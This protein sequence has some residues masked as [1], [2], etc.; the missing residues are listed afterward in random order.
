MRK[1]LLFVSVAAIAAFANPARAQFCPGVSPW[2]FDDVPA[3]DPF[4]G[5]ITQIANQGV[6]LGCAVIDANHRLY[7]PDDNVKRSQMA[8]FMARLG[9]ALPGGSVKSLSQ[10]AGILLSSN[11]ITTTGSIAADTTYLQRRVTGS[12]ATGASIRVIAADGT[13]TCQPDSAGPANAF[14][15]NG[16][17]FGTTAAIGT[18]DAN[19]VHVIA[20]GARAL[21]LEPNAVSPNVIGGSSANN[22]TAGV[23]GGTIGG[24]GV[25]AGTTDPFFVNEGPN[26]VTDAYGTVAGGYNNRAGDDAGTQIDTPFATVGG[27]NQNVAGETYATVGGGSSNVATGIASTISGGDINVASGGRATVGGGAAHFASADYATIA[28]GNANDATGDYSTVGGGNLNA[29]NGNYSAVPG[30]FL[31]IASGVGSLAAGSRAE[32]DSF[33]CFVWGD[34]SVNVPVRCNGG[35]RFVARSL[36]GVFFFTGGTDQA[37]YTGALLPGG[38]TAWVVVSDRNLKENVAQVDA[39]SVLERVVA[40]P[41]ATWNLRSQDRAIR[42]MG[43]MAQDFRAAFGLGE[44]EVGIA[45][46]DADGVALAAIQGLNAKLEAK[47][48]E[49][50]RE[51]AQLRRLVEALIARN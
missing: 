30:G 4:C 49:Q 13:V 14:V 37:S 1:L 32:A 15:Q 19:A 18:T 34:V 11:P 22:V 21:R 7:C 38:G 42:H 39:T 50:A 20:G 16:N 51:I 9:D 28:G 6:T 31:N 2:V 5:F 27:G 25:P 10:G 3:S 33:G 44:S 40:M 45:T 29:A 36:G 12:C 8:A 17:A 35:N 24:G 43:P 47:I 48:A 26:R 41:I 23:R 46:V